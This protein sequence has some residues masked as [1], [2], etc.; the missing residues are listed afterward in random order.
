[1][2]YTRYYSEQIDEIRLALRNAEAVVIGAGAGLS[3]SAGYVYAG[4]RFHENFRDFEEK[5]GFHDM[6]SG[7]FYP[8]TSLE[9]YWAYWSRYVYLNRYLPPPK[10]VY[11]ELLRLVRDRDYFVLTTNVD[12][13]FQRA[14]FDKARLFYTQGDYGLFQCSVPCHHQTYDNEEQI[15]R[16]VAEQKDMKIPSG[17]IPYCPR[18]GKPMTMNLRADDTFVQ[19]RGWEEASRRYRAFLRRFEG[20]RILFLELG[21]G[22]NTPVIIK[23][24]FWRMTM[25]NRNAVYVCINAGEAVCPREIEEQSVCVNADIGAVLGALL[26]G[27]AN[28]AAD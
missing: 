3:T 14:G 22:G 21:V 15:R 12:H 23:Y 27:G 17:L 25:Q 20:R 9:E 7:G 5:Y 6:Y 4:A 18:C 24:P 13:C 10:P 28:A 16:M 26:Q 8:Y 1:M 19:D 2:K 11:G